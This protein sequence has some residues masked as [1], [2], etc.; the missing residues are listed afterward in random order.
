[1][2]LRSFKELD[3][4]KRLEKCL[5]HLYENRHAQECKLNI[6]EAEET[7]NISHDGMTSFSITLRGHIRYEA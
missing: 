7:T 6:I 5:T 4:I 3:E 2:N 1:M